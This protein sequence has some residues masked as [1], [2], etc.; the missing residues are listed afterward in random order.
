MRP[1]ASHK[2]TRQG[3][4]NPS[5]DGAHLRN[6]QRIISQNE[7]SRAMTTRLCR[8]GVTNFTDLGEVVG[9]GDDLPDFHSVVRRDHDH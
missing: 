8:L 9:I 7:Q 2:L 5:G 3:K 1:H 6:V 4:V